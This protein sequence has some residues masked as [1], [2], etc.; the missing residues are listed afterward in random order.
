[1]AASIGTTDSLYFNQVNMQGNKTVLLGGDLAVGGL[2]LDWAGTTDPG[3]GN[4]S[5]LV[6][7]SG[8]TLTLNATSLGGTGV[9][10]TNYTGAGI[11]LNRGTG[12]TLTIQ[13]N[14][15]LGAAQQWVTGRFSGTPLTVTGDISLGANNLKLL[16][17]NAASTNTLSGVIS[18][19]GKVTKEN[20]GVLNISGHGCPVKQ[21]SGF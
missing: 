20:S 21:R 9:A 10:G 4:Y 17:V 11:V 7:N 6:I 13:S 2:A 18:G 19:S 14:V 16:M 1:M 5:S 12:G 3:T 8:N 15:A